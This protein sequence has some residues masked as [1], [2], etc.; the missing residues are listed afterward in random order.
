MLQFSSRCV[1]IFV[2]FL[3]FQMKHSKSYPNLR[4]DGQRMNT[5][6]ANRRIIDEHNLRYDA[7]QVTYRMGLNEFSDLS[8]EEFV[9]RMNGAK[10]PPPT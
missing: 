9:S 1:I 8:H 5:Y 6:F 4:E 7:G 2:S 3:W 10:R